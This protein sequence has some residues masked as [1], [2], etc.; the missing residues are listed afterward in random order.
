MIFLNLIPSNLWYLN[1]RKMLSDEQWKIVSAK[2]RE[3]QN[4]IC[5]SCKISLNELRNKRWFHC[6]EVWDF[7]DELNEVELKCLLC[8]CSKCHSATH[9]GFSTIQNKHNDAFARI[10][11]VNGWD[12]ETTN[13]YIEG[14]FE[15]WSRRSNKQW[16]FNLESIQKNLPDD[17]FEAVKKFIN[18]NNTPSK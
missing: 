16:T 17:C 13:A 10:C 14:N 11:R 3:S 8:L 4:W 5:Y 7:N 12:S 1:L 9:F 18:Q 15:I 2:T 6:H